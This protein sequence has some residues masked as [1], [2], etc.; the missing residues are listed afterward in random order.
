MEHTITCPVKAAAGGGRARPYHATVAGH[1]AATEPK[2]FIPVSLKTWKKAAVGTTL[3]V[4]L[5]LLFLS[6]FI[7][8]W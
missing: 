4:L 2:H 3:A 5:A 7:V 1:D 6:V 8:I